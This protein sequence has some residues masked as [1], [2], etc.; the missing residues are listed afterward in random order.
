MKAMHNALSS[1]SSNLT[2]VNAMSSAELATLVRSQA[3]SIATKD[4]HILALQHQLDW[5]RRQLFGQKSERFAPEP[6]PSQ[7]HLGE[8]LAIPAQQPQ[9]IKIIAAYTRGVAQKDGAESGEELKFFDE[10]KVPVQTIVLVH[11]D[12]E[13][14]SPDQYEVIG[15]KV[16]PTGSR[17]VREAIRFSS[18]VGR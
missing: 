7:M 9:K 2:E 17:S 13:G 18:T 15:E 12:V 4:E 16:T 8:V 10:S 1:G 6:D 5:F 11:A 3:Q 14:L